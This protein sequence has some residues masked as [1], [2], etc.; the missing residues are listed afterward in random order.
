MLQFQRLSIQD[1]NIQFHSWSSW[2]LIKAC[3]YEI[4]YKYMF[5]SNLIHAICAQ[6][7]VT[8]SLFCAR[9]IHW[10][11]AAYVTGLRVGTQHRL[12]PGRAVS[13]VGSV[14]SKP[15]LYRFSVYLS[16]CSP[17]STCGSRP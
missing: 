4:S 1:A 6:H 16:R 12:C 8:E 9:N 17:I 7:A 15:L 14:H 3:V 2:P 10:M 11:Q 5:T 13:W